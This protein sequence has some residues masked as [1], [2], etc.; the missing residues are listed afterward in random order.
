MAIRLV[1]ESRN[2]ETTTTGYTIRHAHLRYPKAYILAAGAALLAQTRDRL[3][4]TCCQRK[5]KRPC[6]SLS[7]RQPRFTF[8]LYLVI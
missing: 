7:K 8:N 4:I 5:P 6:R 3:L 1:S 2:A